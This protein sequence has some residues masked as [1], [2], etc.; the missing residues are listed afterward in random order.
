MLPSIQFVADQPASML[1]TGHKRENRV[2]GEPVEDKSAVSEVIVFDKPEENISLQAESI[3]KTFTPK[4][5][6]FSADGYKWQAG[7]KV[8]A[9]GFSTGDQREDKP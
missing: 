6:P 2:L 4:G 8:P 5:A 3:L 7:F 9:A 1:E